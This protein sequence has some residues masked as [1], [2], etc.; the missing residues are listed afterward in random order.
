MKMRILSMLLVL[1]A[2]QLSFA[3]VSISTGAGVAAVASVVGDVANS[4][5]R[6]VMLPATALISCLD[7]NLEICR[8]A[9]AYVRLNCKSDIILHYIGNDMNRDEAYTVL[10]ATYLDEERN[11]EVLP[12]IDFWSLNRFG[13]IYAVTD[14]NYDAAFVN[15]AVQELDTQCR[16]YIQATVAQQAAGFPIK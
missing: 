12:S 2:S 9:A 4:A 15:K 13:R 10:K 3:D 11:E 5:I 8:P 6:A 1:S 7:H 14:V 16:S